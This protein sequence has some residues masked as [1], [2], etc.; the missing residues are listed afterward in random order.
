MSSFSAEVKAPRISASVQTS[1]V[2]LVDLEVHQRWAPRHSFVQVGHG[3]APGGLDVTL[4]A[5]LT[6]DGDT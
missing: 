6:K 3:C 1:R 4:A 5:Q 2:S